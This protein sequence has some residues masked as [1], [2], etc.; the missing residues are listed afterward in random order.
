[1]PE[2]VLFI[3]NETPTMCRRHVVD[4]YMTTANEAYLTLRPRAP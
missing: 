1:M 4:G 3:I 2:V